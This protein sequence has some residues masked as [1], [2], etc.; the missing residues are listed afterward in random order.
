MIIGHPGQLIR[1]VWSWDSL[2]MSRPLQLR[3]Y[4][5]VQSPCDLHIG[6]ARYSHDS[7]KHNLV[8]NKTLSEAQRLTVMFPNINRDFLFR[9]KRRRRAKRWRRKREVAASR[10]AEV[11]RVTTAQSWFS[12]G[13]LSSNTFTYHNHFESLNTCLLM[14]SLYIMRYANENIIES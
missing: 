8:D 4:L 5:L 2:H 6:Y 1:S 12:K 14:V 11:L 13:Y 3:C 10:L 9:R 7:S